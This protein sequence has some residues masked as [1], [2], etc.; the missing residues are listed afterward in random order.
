[1]L[2]LFVLVFSVLQPWV[3]H[4]VVGRG[5][6]PRVFVREL[7]GRA[8]PLVPDVCALNHPRP[9]PARLSLEC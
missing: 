5:G 9:P 7:E 6:D 3:L 1:M 2:D 4:N 8:R